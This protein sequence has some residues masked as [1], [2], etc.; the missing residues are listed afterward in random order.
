MFKL[1]GFNIF[2]IEIRFDCSLD[3]T[4]IFSIRLVFMSLTIDLSDKI[5]I[6]FCIPNSVAF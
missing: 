6:N 1:S 3:S 5:G 2:G 4:I